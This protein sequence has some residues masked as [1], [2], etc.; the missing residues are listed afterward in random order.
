MRSA[1]RAGKAPA[2]SPSEPTVHES[3]AKLAQDLHAAAVALDE[4]QDRLYWM[5]RTGPLAGAKDLATVEGEV[6][7]ARTLVRAAWRALSPSR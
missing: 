6:Q 5:Q 1:A 2:V 3:W 7:R 4:A